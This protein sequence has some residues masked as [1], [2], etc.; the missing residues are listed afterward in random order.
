MMKDKY[1]K[2]ELNIQLLYMYHRSNDDSVC[3]VSVYKF[4]SFLLGNDLQSSRTNIR[5]V[6]KKKKSVYVVVVNFISF[7]LLVYTPSIPL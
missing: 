2:F 7:R 5:P 4:Y 1:I 6:Q 3:T